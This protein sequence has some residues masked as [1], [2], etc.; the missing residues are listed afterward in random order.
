MKNRGVS[1]E[2]GPSPFARPDSDQRP[3]R[4]AKT[5]SA[6]GRPSE[7]PGSHIGAVPVIA[8]LVRSKLMTCDRSCGVI[9]G[10]LGA[11][12]RR[13]FFPAASQCFMSSAWPAT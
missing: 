2:N 7:L 4:A 1:D 5:L 13:P 11:S 8:V 10:R 9:F 12:G 6:G 3:F